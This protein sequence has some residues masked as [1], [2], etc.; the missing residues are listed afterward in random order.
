MTDA[1]AHIGTPEELLVR[2]RHGIRT[3]LCG[4]QP[5]S[6]AQV[7]GI[8]TRSPLFVPCCALHPWQSALHQPEDML[9]FL[10]CCP[11]VGETGLDSTWCKV[12]M[13]AQMHA[14]LWNLD[15][16][17]RT[18]K[19]IVLHTKGEE[20]RIAR[21]LRQ[22]SMTKVVHWYSSEEPPM[23]YLDQDCYFTIG[24][25][26]LTNRA[27]QQVIALAPLHRL[28]IETDGMG[29]VSWA[30]DEAVPT[31]ALPDVL[32]C[33]MHTIATLRNL[34]IAEVHALI[35]RNFDAL[36]ANPSR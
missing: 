23:E 33:I 18:H 16:S 8:A 25:D 32:S 22:Y 2:E 34:P 26:A 9:P 6:A 3:I 31:D 13:K 12:P 4:T 10:A 5:E 21:I 35:E 20:R 19:P 1:H 14:F 7:T 28:L 30:M 11:I 24:P 36:L 29:A 27:V 15:Y 17:A